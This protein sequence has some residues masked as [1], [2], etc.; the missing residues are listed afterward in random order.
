MALSAVIMART[1]TKQYICTTMHCI[2][3]GTMATLGAC[4][5]ATVKG[6]HT[7]LNAC[8]HAH[9]LCCSLAMLHHGTVPT[10]ITFLCL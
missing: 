5:P 1:S 3:I 4:A 8:T 6:C 7:L 10:V 2:G 9:S